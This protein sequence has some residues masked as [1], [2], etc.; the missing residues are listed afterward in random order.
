MMLGMTNAS[1]G[2][3]AALA[4]LALLCTLSAQDPAKVAAR[5]ARLMTGIRQFTLEGRRSGEGY[6]S[7]DGSLMV[8]QS[9]REK[10]NPFY[11]IYLMDLTT[12]DVERVSPGHGKTTCAWIHPDNRQI[13][14]ASTHSD[15]KARAKQKAELDFRAS[16]KSRRYA[17]DYDETFEIWSWDRKSGEQRRLTH[18]PGYDAEGCYSPDG[19]WIVF[20]SN[21]SA[22]LEPMSKKDR[23][24]FA[25]DKALFMELY[26][27]RA[28]GSHVRRLTFTRGYDGGPFFSH[29]G[30]HI[31]WRRFSENGLTAEIF[32]K[33]LPDGPERQLT[34]I[35][36]M[37]WAPYFHPSGKYLI[38][39]TNRHGFSNFELYLV[40]AD[41]AKEPVRVSWTPG[42]DGLPTFTPDGGTLSWTTNRTK[43]RKSQIFVAKWKHEEALRMLARSPARGTSTAK[44][45]ADSTA[46]GPAE[47]SKKPEPAKPTTSI[48]ASELRE[49]VGVLASER[50]GGRLTGSKGEELATQYVADAFER[51]GLEAQGDGGTWF[52]GFDARISEPGKQPV[53]VRG[54]N[55]L[56]V[57]RSKDPKAPKVV[58]GAHVDHLGRG[59]GGSSR[60][61]AADKGRVHFGADDNASGVAVLLEVAEQ[62]AGLVRSGKLELRRDL[63][64]AAW[65]G[66]EIGLYGSRHYVRSL[67]KSAGRD[68]L[69][70][71]VSCYINLDMVG[72]F[73]KTLILQ[74]IA[75]S[76]VWRREIERRNVPV[77]LPLSLVD[78][79]DLRTDTTS[80]YAAKVPILSAFTGA[81]ADYHSPADTVDKLDYAS[82]Q[83]IGRL[84]ALLVRG[85]ALRAEDPDFVQVS[86]NKAAAKRPQSTRPFLG[87]IPDYAEAAIPGVTISGVSAGA[88]AE[89]AGLKAGDVPVGLAGR[90]IKNIHDYAKALDLL[91][92][93]EQTSIVVVRNGKRIK[94][95]ITP[96]A[97][98]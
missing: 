54:R 34:S 1:I 85:A 91:K 65:S 31:C 82:M 7:R 57:L 37:S 16:G 53:K 61:K 26:L 74:G 64:F 39:T 97:R 81:H 21:R 88:P 79:V 52:Q 70:G 38:F 60:A 95:A 8:F 2:A 55:V 33:R 18:A 4:G 20:G 71:L 29:D 87:T 68:D 75:S 72:R 77:G 17:W 45:R 44:K 32:T 27:M 9:E 62:I 90:E 23:E 42:F 14:Y 89:A 43:E 47:V 93:G 6:Y 3:R 66:E 50:F 78:D 63:V 40:D 48:S 11:Q 69:R 10:N 92:I 94:L 35:G 25:V 13:L 67:A 80:F 41:G 22:F 96:R 46:S 19:K 28:D 36:A 83:R 24:L 98:D 30:T 86:A 59:I 12:G 58:V 73:Q 5:E 51:A 49:H 15:P 76:S 56:G 84:V